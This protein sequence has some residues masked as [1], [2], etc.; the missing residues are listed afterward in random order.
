MQPIPLLLIVALSVPTLLAQEPMPPVPPVQP[1][2]PARTVQARAQAEPMA[3]AIPAPQPPAMPR[4]NHKLA[5]QLVPQDADDKEYFIMVTDGPYRTRFSMDNNQHAFWMDVNG[6][7]APQPDGRIMLK[8]DA[9]L[10]FEGDDMTGEFQ[11][12][13]TAIV[14][15][16]TDTAI[17]RM[18]ERTLMVRIDRAG[19]E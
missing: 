8:F 11:A 17:A 12:D 5:F 16:E 10:H 13:S 7:I 1:A 18:G 6:S 9:T 2:P 3:P 4:Q 14:I 19:K 15:P